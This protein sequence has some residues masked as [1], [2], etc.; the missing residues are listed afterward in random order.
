MAHSDPTS[1]TPRYAADLAEARA[2]QA[3]SHESFNQTMHAVGR[4]VGRFTPWLIEFGSWIF[5]GLIAFI[6]IVLAALITVGPV[7]RAVI[8]ATAAFALALPVNL[9]GLFIL[10]LVQDMQRIGFTDEVARSLR[11]AGFPVD[12]LKDAPTDLEA[13]QRSRTNIIL[14]YALV[15]LTVSAVL[16]LTGVV[17]A[18]WHMSWWIAVAFIVML[19]LSLAA[20]L[21]TLT[22]IRPPDTPAQRERYQRYWEAL[23]AKERE[24]QARKQQQG[25]A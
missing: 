21:A 18:L 20:I 11:E 4:I 19:V 10:R 9:A 7:D 15:I 13:R 14:L 25:G 6:L 8:I 3:A 22:T 24:E 12:D 2:A 5:A 16:T 1:S 23:V 17:A